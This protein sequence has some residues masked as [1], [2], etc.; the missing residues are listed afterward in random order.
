[1]KIIVGFL[2][3][4]LICTS[5]LN[6]DSVF[7]KREYTE[8]GKTVLSFSNTYVNMQRYPIEMVFPTKSPEQKQMIELSLLMERKQDEQLARQVKVL[9]EEIKRNLDFEKRR[10][11][12]QMKDCEALNRSPAGVSKC[13]TPIEEAL[14]RLSND[15]QYY[16]Y[17]R[18]LDGR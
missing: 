18:N 9:Q 13:K 17:K 1:M 14:R 2:L 15:P 10:L 5:G 4:G 16:Y 6:A 7:C 8:S 11:E 12:D 3:C